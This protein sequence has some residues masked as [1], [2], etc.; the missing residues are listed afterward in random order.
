LAELL[1]AAEPNQGVQLTAYS[2]RSAPASG[3]ISALA[4][5]RFFITTEIEKCEYFY[6][7]WVKRIFYTSPIP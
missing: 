1:R 4:L 2:V 7:M 6:S 3:S 5:G